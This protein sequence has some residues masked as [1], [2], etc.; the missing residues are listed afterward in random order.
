[1]NNQKQLQPSQVLK[2]RYRIER[3]L[4]R[5]GSG[6]TYVAT[7]INDSEGTEYVIKHLQPPSTDP[8]VLQTTRRLFQKEAGILE[9]LGTHSQI[10]QLYDSFE[11]EEELYLVQEFIDGH[12]LTQEF[13]DE[14]HFSEQQ[15]FQLLQD[16]LKVLNYVHSQG[17]IHRDVKPDNLIRRKQDDQLVLIDFGSI[18]AIQTRALTAQGNPTAT[19]SIGTSGYIASEQG[20]GKPR[21]NSDIYS[22][23]L[24]CIQALTGRHPTQIPDDS[25]TLEKDWRQNVNVSDEFAY[26]LDQMIRFRPT[27]RY[28]STQEVQETL[29][30]I[31][32]G[33]FVLPF[34]AGSTPCA[35]ASSPAELSQ[36]PTVAT[37]PLPKKADY[38]KLIFITGA[39]AIALV[40]AALG[41]WAKLS[42]SVP[43]PQPS[44]SPSAVASSSTLE[45]LAVP[46][47]PQSNDSLKSRSNP[48]PPV[49]RIAPPQQFK[50]E[51]PSVSS[52]TDASASNVVPPPD[53]SST[54]LPSVSRPT[55][56][57]PSQQ[58]ARPTVPRVEPP[59]PQ[60]SPVI[61]RQTQSEIELPADPALGS[62]E[63]PSDINP[64]CKPDLTPH[65]FFHNCAYSGALE[66][67]GIRGF[68]SLI[69]YDAEEIVQAGV[70]A[71]L[72][73]PETIQNKGYVK[74]IKLFLRNV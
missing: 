61:L 1:M 27:D 36:P 68:A 49:D 8:V 72:L 55:S 42:L 5:G 58:P 18:K 54:R 67:Y 11:E 33:E 34:P 6:V 29:Q 35:T 28:Q 59:S 51:S 48:V 17:V 25:T 46:S 10:P 57:S 70:D 16:V 2:G 65:N 47:K 56:P 26:V 64:A 43:A 62:G 74:A 22:L 13:S 45:P 23:G 32:E 66:Y 9:A 30:Q 31:K 3:S 73:P 15:T 60:R 21:L 44:P 4:G 24:V 40:I 7:D 63:H 71:E 20:Q 38:T 69:E 37:P 39:G 12:P 19:V 52:S 50:A 14:Q 41:S 53:R